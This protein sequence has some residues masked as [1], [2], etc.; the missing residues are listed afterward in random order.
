MTRETLK[1]LEQYKPIWEFYFKNFY[2]TSAH[3]IRGLAEFINKTTGHYTN[4][5]CSGCIVD[6]IK[7]ARNLYE[8]EP[9]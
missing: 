6:L 8:N 1:E 4:T 2:T 3:D 5:N 7:T 9:K